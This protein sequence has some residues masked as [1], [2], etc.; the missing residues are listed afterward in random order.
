MEG[1][2]YLRMP[3]LFN[4]FG[5]QWSEVGDEALETF[6]QVGR[7]G[8]YILGQEVARFEEA[9]SAYW[10]LKQ[11]VG[12]GNG[13]DAI[14]IGLRALGCSAGDRVLTSPISAFAT[15]LA[16]IKLGA[17]PVFVDCDSYGLA[18]LESCAELLRVRQDIGYFVPVHLYGH[19]LNLEKLRELKE[20]HGLKIVEDCAQSIGSNWKDETCG[21]AGQLAATSFYPTKNLGALGDGGAV[22]TDEEQYA[23]TV[24]ML[25]D[26][27]QSAKYRH[28]EIGY[29]SRLDE[30]QAAY[31][32]RV[33][34][35]RLPTW[36]ARRQEIASRYME[37]IENPGLRVPGK[38]EF[39]VSTWHLFPVLVSAG[40]KASFMAFMRDQAVGVAEHYP[41]A[42]VDQPAMSNV[43]YEAPYGCDKAREWCRSQ[44]SLPIHPY[45]S[46]SEVS[47]VVE[48]CNQW[49]G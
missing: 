41:T 49:K 16:I 33:A 26:Y 36:A 13:L 40:N 37:S 38:P 45:L 8:W 4:D 32:C 14:E 9:L 25:R 3:I 31:L 22:L 12:V 29:N 35:P 39:S 34:L 42:L 44:V 20:K 24:R 47:C 6:R 1:T 43:R 5:R 46:D 7:S 17:I 19:C 11:A 21:T 2:A 23:V 30:L 28:Q 27:G 48:L 10:G 15:V 18:D